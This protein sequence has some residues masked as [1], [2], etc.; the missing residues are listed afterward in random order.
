MSADISREADSLVKH[1]LEI[2]LLEKCL[3]V[4]A[5]DVND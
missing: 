2:L 4:P 5:D 1:C 3:Y